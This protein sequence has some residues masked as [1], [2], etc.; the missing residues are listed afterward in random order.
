MKIVFL[1][2]ARLD[3]PNNF[4]FLLIQ[5]FRGLFS[6]EAAFW[7]F[8]TRYF[9][10]NVV[11]GG[12]SLTIQAQ[13]IFFSIFFYACGLIRS[14]RSF[15]FWRGGPFDYPSPE[16]KFSAMFYAGGLIRPAGPPF[17]FWGGVSLTIPS[18]KNILIFEI[19]DARGLIRSARPLFL[20]GVSL[21][22]PAQKIF[23]FFAIFYAGGLIRSARSFFFWGR[24]FHYP[25]PQKK[26]FF[27]IFD[28]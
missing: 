19:F 22:I 6:V 2:N 7:V 4:G 3:S 25:S 20:G 14:A 27:A 24:P 9:F 1:V 17:F 12:V 23:L 26:V 15:F 21:T 10:H 8:R 16:K 13:K 5:V 11:N 28:A 18:Q